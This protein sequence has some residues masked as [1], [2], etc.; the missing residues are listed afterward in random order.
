MSLT[1]DSG[2]T[3]QVAPTILANPEASSQSQP[4]NYQDAFSRN[5]GLI[6]RDEQERLRNCKVAIP[7]MGGVGGLHLVTLARLGIGKF[8]IADPDVFE[9]VN[10][11]RQYGASV[12]TIGRSKVEVMSEVARSINPDVEISVIKGKVDRSNADDFLSDC[13]ILVDGIDLYAIEARRH[14][15]NRA[16]AHNIPGITAGPMGFSTC[17]LT[18]TPSG[19]SFDQYFDINDD[20]SYGRKVIAFLMGLCPRMLPLQYMDRHQANPISGSAPSVS[21]GCQLAAGV[22]AS[23]AVKILLGRGPVKPAPHYRIFDAYLGKF[24][25]GNLRMGNRSPLQRI[26]RKWLEREWKKRF[27]TLDI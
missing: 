10:F 9:S 18:F 25:S 12:E 8:I 3:F 16:A 24:E 22:M 6:S 7:G 15:F 20:T 14:V 13:D 11:N 21:A 23:E 4:W 1:T 17:W 2:A 19:M 27:E 26:K 5:Y